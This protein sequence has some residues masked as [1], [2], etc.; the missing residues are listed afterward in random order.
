MDQLTVD[1]APERPVLQVRDPK[2]LP[3]L[4]RNVVR[5]WECAAHGITAAWNNDKLVEAEHRLFRVIMWDFVKV[6]GLIIL[7]LVIFGPVTAVVAVVSPGLILNLFQLAPVWALNLANS[8]KEAR[9]LMEDVFFAE[10]K[11]VKPEICEELEQRLKEVGGKSETMWQRFRMSAHFSILSAA[12]NALGIL[13][14]GSILATVGQAIVLA[15]SFGVK[16][17]DPY[18]RTLQSHT[19]KKNFIYSHYFLLMGFSLPLVW[20]TSIPV[21]NIFAIGYAQAGAAHLLRKVAKLNLRERSKASRAE[22]EQVAAPE[23]SLNQSE[24]ETLLKRKHLS[25]EI[26]P[27]EC[28]SEQ[29]DGKKDD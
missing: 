15:E 1:K 18:L 19:K 2:Q 24:G 22:E 25:A 26:G 5:G 11:R 8:D 27:A 10:L 9:G 14:F 17:L 23:P 16:M 21:V 29:V 3:H 28:E 13:P 6:Y 7:G 20:L 12:V 4:V